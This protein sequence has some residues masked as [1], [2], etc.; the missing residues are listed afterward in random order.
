MGWLDWEGAFEADEFPA[1]FQR[2]ANAHEILSEHGRHSLQQVLNLRRPDLQTNKDHMMPRAH[3]TI[4]QCSQSTTRNHQSNLFVVHNT[5]KPSKR[6]W[7]N[8]LFPTPRSH[9]HAQ[10]AKEINLLQLSVKQWFLFACATSTL[11]V[12]HCLLLSVWTRGHQK[13]NSTVK[14]VWYF[15]HTKR[16]LQ[17]AVLSP[18]FQKVTTTPNATWHCTA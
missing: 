14:F 7:Q 3:Q 15:G 17:S 8:S 9:T 1:F 4:V 12:P 10:N 2:G 5:K 18:N 6:L 11:Q 16:V 13:L